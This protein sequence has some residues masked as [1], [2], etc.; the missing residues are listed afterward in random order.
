MNPLLHLYSLI[1]LSFYVCVIGLHVLLAFSVHKNAVAWEQD[2][3]QLMFIGP[4]A[5]AVAAFV[6]GVFGLLVYC[7]MHH[8]TLAANDIK[9]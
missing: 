3:G 6:C 1:P 9:E 7:L 8:S 4:H 2:G 5:W